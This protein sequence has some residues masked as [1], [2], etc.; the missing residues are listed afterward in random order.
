[1][2]FGG[3]RG[4]A[5]A[6][7][8]ALVVAACGPS[9]APEPVQQPGIV[10]TENAA[11]PA[12]DPVSA[13]QTPPLQP[14]PVYPQTAKIR[15]DGVNPA[16][17]DLVTNAMGVPGVTFA[18][19]MRLG[20][21]DVQLPDGRLQRVSMAAVDPNAFRVFTPAGTAEHT[22]LWQRVVEGNAAFTHE[23]GQTLGLQLAAKVTAGPGVPL[24]VGAFASNGTPPVAQAVVSHA[25][26]ALLGIGGPYVLLAS[27]QDP[28]TAATVAQQLGQRLGATAQVVQDPRQPHPVSVPGGQVTSSNVWDLLAQC[29]AGGNWAINSGNGYYGGLQFLPE[30]WQAVGG[31]GLPHQA[32]REEQIVRGTILQQRQGWGAWPACAAKL[33]LR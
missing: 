13:S 30:S 28:S 2:D 11:P 32:T 27:V 20:D 19:V 22:D 15:V 4:L 18:T 23:V 7:A 25:E 5:A 10:I 24:R 33:G 31:V 21:V 26:G 29:E 14:G 1:M 16:A 6:A 9:Q 3:R 17:G 12:P 8:A